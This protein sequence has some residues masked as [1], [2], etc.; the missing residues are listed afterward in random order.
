MKLCYFNCSR[1]Y[2]KISDFSH[3]HPNNDKLIIPQKIRLIT[4]QD[5]Y[6]NDTQ[7]IRKTDNRDMFGEYA[8]FNEI[9]F[10]TNDNSSTASLSRLFGLLCHSPHKGKILLDKLTE[11]KI[12]QF[13]VARYLYFVESLMFVNRD[14]ISATPHI[15][16]F[17]IR[18]SHILDLGQ[19]NPTNDAASLNLS[20]THYGSVIHPSTLNVHN[21]F[22]EYCDTWYALKNSTISQ[23]GKKVTFTQFRIA[24]PHGFR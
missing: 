11:E 20:S 8:L 22:V 3:K 15:R 12:S 21:F 13:Y 17:I 14:K 24:P 7:P 16:S 9:A 18:C 1:I 2:E 6:N 23:L 10:F 4:G 19:S 5:A